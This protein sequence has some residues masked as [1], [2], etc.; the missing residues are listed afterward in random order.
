[1]PAS[2]PKS[3]GRFDDYV[4]S[5]YVFPGR[6]FFQ[7]LPRLM[8]LQPPAA[9]RST[10]RRLLYPRLT[11]KRG[12]KAGS[13]GIFPRSVT[14][15]TTFT[16]PAWWP[17]DPNCW[18]TLLCFGLFVK[19]ETIFEGKSQWRDM[20]APA[21]GPPGT[22]GSPQ[23]RA[24]LCVAQGPRKP[25]R[26]RAWR[27]RLAS[28]FPFNSLRPLWEGVSYNIGERL[29]L[30][31]FC[32]SLCCDSNFYYSNFCCSCVRGDSLRAPFPHPQTSTEISRFLYASFNHYFLWF[33]ADNTW[34]VFL[35][36]QLPVNSILKWKQN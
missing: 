29:H 1:M 21:Q 25:T 36:S 30:L 14:S 17:A 23:S 31:P 3:R 8:C 4:I 22:A 5:L 7:H 2:F 26:P 16:E 27:M 13:T 20:A 19:H 10:D 34:E 11:G 12:P 35:K 24:R 6:L 18:V 33:T 15:N 9:Q 32:V 28:I